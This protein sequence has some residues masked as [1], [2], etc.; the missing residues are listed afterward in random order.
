MPHAFIIINLLPKN[1]IVE[2][3]RPLENLL[4]YPNTTNITY[5]Q[6][7]F[8]NEWYHVG[9]VDYFTCA[10]GHAPHPDSGRDN[11]TCIHGEWSG[12]RPSCFG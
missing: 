1:L 5:S 7:S 10:D 8:A 6:L 4:P 2:A 9:T 3:C 12:D 11:T